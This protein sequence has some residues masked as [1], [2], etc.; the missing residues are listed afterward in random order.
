MTTSEAVTQ[1]LKERVETKS[2]LIWDKQDHELL[3]GM[4][5]AGCEILPLT[6]ALG[7][8]VIKRLSADEALLSLITP[9]YICISREFIITMILCT[10]FR[11]V[12]IGKKVAETASLENLFKEN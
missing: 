8:E 5:A 6:K 3:S 9:G 11:G 1:Y 10:Y 7:E 2:S 4:Q 12:E